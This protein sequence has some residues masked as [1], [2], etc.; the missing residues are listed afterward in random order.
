MKDLK[1]TFTDIFIERPVL[2]IVVNLVIIIAGVNAI[3]SAMRGSG[4]FTVRQYP[5]S[6][7]AT[8]V[9]TTPY[10]GADAELVRGFVTTPLE[11]AIASADNIDYLT[12][13]SVQGLSTI[14][15]RLELNTDATKA[16]AEISSKVDQ[17]RG[18]LP[19]EAEVPSIDIE[20]ADSE[21]A[22]MYLSF[23]SD[24]LE[25][26]QVTD[27]LVRV[28]QP[29]LTA[30][31][32]VQR[33]EILGA[34]TYAV[35]I[36]LQPEKLAAYNI[37]PSEVRQALAANNFLAS[38][39]STKGQYIQANL[40]TNTS[41]TSVEEFK[42]LAVREVDGSIIR[43]EDVAEVVLDAEFYDVDVRFS[44]EEA[45]FMGIW[46]LPNANALD[47]IARVKAE[48]QTLQ[49]RFPVGFWGDIAYDSTDY[50]STAIKEVVKTLL[51]TLAIVVVVIFLFIGA[52]R[53]VVIPIL[54]IPLSLIGGIFLMQVFGFSINLLTLLA[55]V[56]SV[57]LVVDDAIVVVENVE[58]HLREGHSP[59][60]AAIMTGRELAGPI[61]AMTITLA[62]VYTPVAFAGGL[63][64]SLFRE[65]AITLAGTVVISGFVALTL[66]PM[67]ASQLLRTKDENKGFAG[68]INR[69]FD[70]LRKFYGKIL[71]G[72]LNA[73]PVA[74]IV[75]VLIVLSL[76]PLFI[77][78]SM[79]T[80]LA[81]TEDQ[82]V[83]FGIVSTDAQNTVEQ[84]T[85]YTRQVH[86]AFMAIPEAQYS[87]QLTTPTGGFGGVLMENW[88]ERDRTIFDIRMEL[89]GKLAGI[90][91]IQLFPVLPAALPGGSNFPVE[92]VIA[93]TDDIET[94]AEF[95]KTIATEAT[96]SG[97]FAF[98]PDIDIKIDTPEARL[99]LDR[100]RVADLGLNLQQV[101]T[102][103]AT[104]LSGSYVNRF[105]IDGLSYK[106]IPQIQRTARLNPEDLTEI[107]V[108]GPNGELV[109]LS[110]FAR[111]EERVVPRSINRFNQLNAVTISGI[112]AA[113]LDAALKAL[114]AAAEKIL[115]RSYRVDYA[116]ESRQLRK[117][118]SR[119]L[120]ALGL[121][122]ILIF[123]VLAAQFNSFRDPVI[124]LLG[125]APLAMFGALIFT[126]LRAPGDPW[127]PH[128]SWGWTTSLNIY[129]QVGIITLI[130][131]IAKNGILIV[132]F[133]NILQRRGRTKRDAIQE[134]AILRLRPILMTTAAT[135]FGH[136]MLIFVTGAGA[137]ARNSIGLVLVL[138]MAIGTFFTVF[139]LPPL[140]FLLAKDR[141]AG[142]AS[143]IQRMKKQHE[144][145]HLENV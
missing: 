93:S 142:E 61:V 137:E 51:E 2:S 124:I 77:L 110:S 123:L 85:Q 27:Y 67:M 134:A 83:V 22:A 21:I 92:F 18:D 133:A 11:R 20:S 106:V 60:E 109:P 99:V 46:V 36:W 29:A 101:G 130:G 75:W 129:S 116:G 8:I 112:P 65:F 58:R 127:T 68:H 44:G 57:G 70:R 14:R 4:D 52:P 122:L 54:S 12:S 120:P 100:D 6:E 88:S 10:I 135:V 25:T 84:T 42:Q 37:S 1:R 107:H 39:G 43:L 62:S 118:G 113:P 79:S 78:S 38:V 15:A 73:R 28:V 94:I 9:V 139:L 59:F 91:G 131:L 13:S 97:L 64:G 125:S 143:S 30:L 117:E 140:Y 66:S 89:M 136:M 111:V 53:A 55:I 102:D 87:F 115:P 7:N 35:R 128:W 105:S 144:E 48:M 33:A 49:D 121:A 104:M 90:P 26:N 141:K 50:I 126:A 19:P 69:N 74:Y 72:I 96:A 31:P 98:P 5:R 82:G 63:T 145:L 138:G 32:G 40:K 114:E 45:V 3:A 86:D 24:I 56:L 71:G 47:V 119:F 76:V 23:G 80:E 17:V 16:L 103:L 108:S 41:L 132:E 34:R 81:P 95:A